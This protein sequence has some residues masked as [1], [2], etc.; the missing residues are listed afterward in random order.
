[1]RLAV[2]FVFIKQTK[3][4]DERSEEPLSIARKS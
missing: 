1:V 3:G 4:F 2:A